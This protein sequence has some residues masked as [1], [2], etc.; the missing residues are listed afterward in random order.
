MQLVRLQAYLMTC[1]I[2]GR[3]LTSEGNC[4]ADS[5]FI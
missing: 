3:G 5:N 4:S 1:V 2:C